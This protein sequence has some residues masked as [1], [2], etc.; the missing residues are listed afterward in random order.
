VTIHE[1]TSVLDA[2]PPI[3]QVRVPVIPGE[4][5]TDLA[6]RVL[7]VE[8]RTLVEVLAELSGSMTAASPAPIRALR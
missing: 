2:G 3:V 5:A 6:D 8:H 4:S 7:E 1:V